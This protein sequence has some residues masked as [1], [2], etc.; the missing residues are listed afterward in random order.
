MRLNSFFALPLRLKN[1]QS[2][3]VAI[4]LFLSVTSLPYKTLAQ[5]EY[6][7]N[8][9][10][11][12]QTAYLIGPGDRIKVDIFQVQEYSGEYSILVDGTISLPLI[13]NLKAQGLTLFQLGEILS[14]RYAA[15]LRRPLVTVTLVAPRPLRIAIAGEVNR[16]GS[17][18]I[19]LEKD[20]QQF[21]SVTDIIQ[22]AGGITASAKISQVQIRRS[23]NNRQQLITIDLV[24]L[25]QQGDLNQDFVLRDGDSI[26]VPT[27]EAIDPTDSRLLAE[28]NFGLKAGQP[29]TVAIV[30]EVYRPGS[31]KIVPQER[32]VNN[33][34]ANVE[35][36]QPPRLTQAIDQAGGIKPLADIR[37]IEIRRPTRL[38]ELQTI[39]LNLWELLQTGD[40]NQDII[41]QEGD[42]IVIPTAENLNPAESEALAAASF[43]PDTIK[44]NVVGEV[45]RPGTIEVPPNTPLN[46]A[47]LA[48]GGFNYRR[49][50]DAVVDLV[51]LNP[52]GTV[53]KREVEIDFSQ[54]VDEEKNPAMRNNDVVFVRRS[55]ITAFTDGLGAI[56]TP[57]IGVSG[58][59][60]NLINGNP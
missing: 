18:E 38:G 37:N 35:V 51:R 49:A 28:A 2:S 29:V 43:S 50:N 33:N 17:Y 60:I 52:N 1:W 40:L 32:T 31:Y 59:I 22:Q 47:V 30:G 13:G 42:T 48:A 41:L 8:N 34:N 14:Q 36:P 4:I 6:N 56:I 9:E 19:K 3:T 58:S 24:Q 46:Q 45:N 57:L 23:F 55:G 25:L 15:Y 27:K 20:Q 10:S 7:P 44:V 53:S 12:I 16:P 5:S 21:P 26:F 39:T 54:G 11:Q